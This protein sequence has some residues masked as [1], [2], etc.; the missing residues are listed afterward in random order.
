MSMNNT[1]SGFIKGKT[2]KIIIAVTSAVIIGGI[3]LWLD[4][5]KTGADPIGE[6][7]TFAAKRGPL[8]ISITESGTIKARDQ[9]ILKSEVEGRT[10][11]ISLI[12]EGAAVKKGDLLVELDASSLLDSKIDQEIRAQNAEASYVSSKENLAVVENQA[13]SDNDKA[14]LTFQ[15]AKLDLKKYIDPNGEYENQLKEMQSEITLANEELTRAEKERDSASKLFKEKYISQT[16]QQEYELA[17]KK[18]DLKLQV[19]QSNLELLKNFT[20]KRN[21][22]QLES[23]VSQAEMALERTTRKAKADI[24]QAEADLKAKEAEYKRQQS[25]LEKIEDQINKTKIYAP[26]DGLVI[27]ATSAQ[28]AGWRGVEPLD[29]GQEVRERQELIYLPTAASSKV[30]VDIHESSLER[31]RPGLAA[32]ITVDALAGKKFYGSVARIAPLPDARSMWMNPDLKVY[33]ADIYLENNDSSL[34]T[35]MSCQTEIII[36]QYDDAVYIPVQCVLRVRGESTVYVLNGKSPEPRKVE[37]GLDNNNMV[38]IISGLKEGEIVLLTP[39]LKTAG[40]DFSMDANAIALERIP[41]EEKT[42][43]DKSVEQNPAEKAP[44]E[45]KPEQDVEKMRQ[46]FESMSPEEREKMRNRVRGG[47]NKP[48]MQ[49]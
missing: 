3:I 28:R 17:F 44:E 26:V 29:E 30:E 25:K 22:A 20:Y 10:S 6:S 15:F 38:R 7:V 12:P 32:I 14:Q 47:E 11:I 49:R 42:P 46:R 4:K 18:W 40:T 16:E 8:K 41:A 37:I 39:P 45:L 36:E 33:N 13:K 5:S 24:V 23:D 1:K 31:I 21:L 9:V 35:G 2:S 48:E 34:R 27:Y 43:E 19:A